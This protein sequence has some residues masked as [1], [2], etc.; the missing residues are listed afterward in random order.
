[1]YVTFSD[2][3]SG[4]GICGHLLHVVDEDD[5][6]P[7]ARQRAMLLDELAD[8]V[9]RAGGL[10]P[11]QEEQV[12]AVAGDAVERRAQ[13][14]VVGELRR[15]AAL[16]H[17]RPE[18]LLADVLDLDRAG[19]VRQVGQRR[20]HRDEPVHEVGLVV[21][22]AQVEHVRLTARCDVARHLEGHR[23]L[24]GALGAADQHQLPGPQAGADRLV[25][26]GE[27]QRDRL[28]LGEVPG[29]DAFVQIDRGRRAPSA[30]AMLPLSVSRR[31]PLVA[32]GAGWGR[33][34]DRC[35]RGRFLPGGMSRFLPRCG[36]RSVA[37]AL[38]RIT[39]PEVLSHGVLTSTVAISSNVATM[40]RMAPS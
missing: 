35:S 38:P 14:R 13:P 1:M 11:A 36:R 28:V 9:D 4:S 17:P 18:D 5:E 26:R 8:V 37:P 15:A 6:P 34:S 7:I 33:S 30:G 23:R 21:L 29:G 39:H 20:L 24:A 25:E 19:L 32:D 40:A 3:F 31:Q 10:R 12:L 16:G 22:E 27:A 2:S